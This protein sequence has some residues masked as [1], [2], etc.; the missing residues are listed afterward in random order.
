MDRL[1]PPPEPSNILWTFIKAL[2]GKI[3]I[4]GWIIDMIT[5][6]FD[7]DPNTGSAPGASSE[8]RERLGYGGTLAKMRWDQVDQHDL[9]ILKLQE[10]TMKLLGVIGF[11]QAAMVN[12]QTPGTSFAVVRF[13]QPFGPFIGCTYSTST[14]RYTF[15]SKGLWDVY[16]KIRWDVIF[17]QDINTEMK[18]VVRAPN[19]TVHRAS[20]VKGAGGDKVT[21]SDLLR[22]T[23]PSA[24]YTVEVQALSESQ[25][26]GILGT[27][28]YSAF[29]VL[30]ISDETD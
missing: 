5:G 24:G 6:D 11:G 17:Y 15:Q 1:H 2:F 18:I 20:A 27:T 22:V 10:D 8:I 13:N 21:D 23:V 16:A 19:G 14:Y 26:R 30:K 28:E 4:V 7:P 12:H 3:P 9:N 25:G 29:T